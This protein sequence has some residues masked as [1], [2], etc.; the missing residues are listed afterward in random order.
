MGRQPEG[1]AYRDLVRHADGAVTA[2]ALELTPLPVAD[3]F[4]PTS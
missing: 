2:E 3:L 4:P 1:R